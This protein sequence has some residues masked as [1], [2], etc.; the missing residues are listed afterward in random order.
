[1]RESPCASVFYLNNLLLKI[2]KNNM[3]KILN[4]LL[5]A[6]ILAFT[7]CNDDDAP[8]QEAIPVTYANIAGTWKLESWNDHPT[9]DDRYCY[10]VIERRAD[11]ENGRRPLTMYL[12]I[13]SDKSH[14]ETSTYELTEDE[15]LGGTIISGMYDFGA[16]FWTNSYLISELTADRMVWIVTDDPADVSVYVRCNEVPEDIQNGTRAL[17]W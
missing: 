11:E 17:H 4:Y 15:E 2:K 14:R 1:M 5:M 13:D 12:N 3:R 8:I 16:G 10:L 6:A 9:S 7:A